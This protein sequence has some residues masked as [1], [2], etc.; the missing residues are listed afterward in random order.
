VD[1]TEPPADLP[2]AEPATRVLQPAV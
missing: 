2:F 1:L